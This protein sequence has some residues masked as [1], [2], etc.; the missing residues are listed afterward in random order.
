M[1]AARAL[2][3][4]Y[5]YIY[6]YGTSTWRIKQTIPVYSDELRRFL[7]YKLSLSCLIL[8][9]NDLKLS[10]RRGKSV[11]HESWKVNNLNT[12]SSQYFQE[13]SDYQAFLFEVVKLTPDENSGKALCRLAL[14]VPSKRKSIFILKGTCAATYS[15]G[16]YSY[17]VNAFT[18]SLH[19]PHGRYLA[20]MCKGTVLGL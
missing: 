14:C 9:K 11:R 19:S 15:N 3:V 5:I 1:E 6:I 7:I 8:C 20:E 12:K 4:R 10:W 18:V 2:K 17:L 13:H 16:Q